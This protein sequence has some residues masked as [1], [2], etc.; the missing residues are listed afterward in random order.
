MNYIQ[1]NNHISCSKTEQ[2]Q[3]KQ[4]SLSICVLFYDI[5]IYRYLIS[6]RT[7]YTKCIEMNFN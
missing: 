2:V 5:N 1:I 3:S 4:D 6:Y 7:W